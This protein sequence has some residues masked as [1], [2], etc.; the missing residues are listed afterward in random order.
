MA[1]RIKG[2]V[3]NRDRREATARADKRN[4][5][6]APGRTEACETDTG[7][8]MTLDILHFLLKLNKQSRVALGDLEGQCVRSSNVVGMGR[9]ISTDD[10][11]HPGLAIN[12]QTRRKGSTSGIARGHQS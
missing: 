10:H 3:A 12:N 8:G 5:A 6:S 7:A 1:L 11:V 9:K 4:S 2:W